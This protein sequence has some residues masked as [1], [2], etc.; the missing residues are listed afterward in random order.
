[1]VLYFYEQ[2]MKSGELREVYD[3]GSVGRIKYESTSVYHKIL[4][5]SVRQD[6]HSLIETSLTLD[7][8]I[9]GDFLRTSKGRCRQGKRLL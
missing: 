8:L 2:K 7:L 3:L 9:A 6:K 1:M 5:T 4:E